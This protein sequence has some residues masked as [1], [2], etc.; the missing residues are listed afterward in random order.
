M[1]RIESIGSAPIAAN[2]LLSIRMISED[3]LFTIRPV[4]LSHKA[5]T[6]TLPV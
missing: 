4:F 6:V 3:S 1:R 5:G 2:S